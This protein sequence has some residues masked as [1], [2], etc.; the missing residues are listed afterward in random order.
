M[1]ATFI[2][3]QNTKF[4][5]RMKRIEKRHSLVV[6]TEKN[7]TEEVVV[8]MYLEEWVGFLKVILEG[9]VFEERVALRD[10]GKI[11]NLD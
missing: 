8:E 11:I 10:W 4:V 1:H 5:K 2:I 3:K 9:E 6:V 7:V